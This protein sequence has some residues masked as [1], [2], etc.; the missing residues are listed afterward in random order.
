MTHAERR[1]LRSDFRDEIEEVDADLMG[2]KFELEELMERIREPRA[3]KAE[4]KARL[5]ELRATRG[6]ARV[7]RAGDE[8]SPGRCCKPR[9]GSLVPQD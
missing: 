4:L 8:M 3:R 2:A 5:A 9:P 1:E 7:V 6:L